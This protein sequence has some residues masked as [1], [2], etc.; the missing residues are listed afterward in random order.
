MRSSEKFELLMHSR[1]EVRIYDKLLYRPE[2]HCNGWP[3]NTN[4]GNEM[5]ADKIINFIGIEGRIAVSPRR[6]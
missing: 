2:L 4:A 3:R 5:K 1:L 6:I